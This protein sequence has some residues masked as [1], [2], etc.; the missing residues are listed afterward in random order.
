MRELH[1]PYLKE[2]D[3][4]R[5]MHARHCLAAVCSS[6]APQPPPRVLPMPPT[7]PQLLIVLVSLAHVCYAALLCALCVFRVRLQG[8]NHRQGFWFGACAGGA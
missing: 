7:Y 2:H 5:D 3:D 1:V 6:F 4:S 8:W